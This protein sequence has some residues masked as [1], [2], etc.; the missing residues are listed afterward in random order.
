M[1]II[2]INIGR[3]SELHSLGLVSLAH[4]GQ[5]LYSVIMIV[6]NI[7]LEYNT[8]TKPPHFVCLASVFVSSLTFF[9]AHTSMKDIL[10]GKGRR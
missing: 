4:L 7:N 1:K 8:P 9:A 2:I 3:F 5:P 10:K 6:L